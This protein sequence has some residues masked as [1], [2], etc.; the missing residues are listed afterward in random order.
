MRGI[1][2]GTIT[3]EGHFGGMVNGTM[4]VPANASA[5]IGGM[6]NG[7]LI[8]EQGA[9]VLISGMVNGAVINRGA[10]IEVTGMVTG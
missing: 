10:T 8:V 9:R 1:H 7:T 4:I 2:D 5:E 3:V 6:V